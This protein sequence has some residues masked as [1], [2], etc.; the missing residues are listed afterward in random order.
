MAGEKKR[1]TSMSNTF[2]QHGGKGS[3]NV[4]AGTIVRN[5]IGIQ[6]GRIVQKGNGNS[7][8]NCVIGNSMDKGS[9]ISI[10][11]SV[12]GSGNVFEGNVIT[13]QGPK[14]SIPGKNMDR[15]CIIK[16]SIE[17]QDG[18][19]EEKE[20]KYEKP[21]DTFKVEVHGDATQVEVT[22]GDATVDGSAQDV[23]VTNGKTT[24]AGNVTN[25]EGTNV[26]TTVK[27]SITKMSGVNMTTNFH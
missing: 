11:G 1:K 17:Y 5:G 10:G 19:K 3:V 6:N 4:Q 18:D 21:P 22:N 9:S 26:K 24:I 2:V 25:F 8:R 27:G 15:P 14:V 12:V 13:V 23:N 7:I 16:V 20:Y